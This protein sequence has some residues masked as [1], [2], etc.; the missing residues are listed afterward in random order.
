MYAVS[1]AGRMCLV[2]EDFPCTSLIAVSCVVVV[3]SNK[4]VWLGGLVEECQASSSCSP[5]TS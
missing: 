2:R 1:Y 5:G 4:N 3:I